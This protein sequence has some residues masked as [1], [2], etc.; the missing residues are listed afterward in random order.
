MI[1]MHFS[2]IGLQLREVIK[3]IEEIVMIELVRLY[4][5]ISSVCRCN[6]ITTT[7]MMVRTF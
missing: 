5:I 6:N 4:S 7:S 1:L 2:R 3:K